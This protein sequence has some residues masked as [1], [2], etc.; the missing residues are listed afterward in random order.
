MKEQLTKL[1]FVLFASFFIYFFLLHIC[2][3]EWH[4]IH[5][6][7]TMNGRKWHVPRDSLHSNITNTFTHTKY[8]KKNWKIKKKWNKNPKNKHIARTDLYG[9]S[10]CVGRW[11][12]CR[13]LRFSR[14]TSKRNTF[15]GC[16]AATS[17]AANTR[18][19][20]IYTFWLVLPSLFY[21][22]TTNFPPDST[23][24]LSLSQ[25]KPTT[26][27]TTTKI[28]P[29]PN[30]FTP[31]FFTDHNQKKKK[32][33]LNKWKPTEKYI[34]QSTKCHTSH[35]LHNHSIAVYYLHNSIPFQH[36]ITI[37]TT[38]FNSKS[39]PPLQP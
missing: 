37:P 27:T 19:E 33:T 35:T 13:N 4:T 17:S 1:N 26:T 5:K 18:C 14:S 30:K 20:L 3:C 21:N 31:C 6:I 39:I 7:E 28:M 38:S 22:H 23:L 29:K 25:S 34:S 9:I 2:S 8:K 12:S 24:S 10:T 16:N 15:V 11:S 32:K 36:W